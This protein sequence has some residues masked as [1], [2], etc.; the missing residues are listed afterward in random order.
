MTT[1]QEWVK[2]DT[3]NWINDTNYV[4]RYRHGPTTFVEYRRKEFATYTFRYRFNSSML[5]RL[6]PICRKG[7]PPMRW[8]STRT[9]SEWLQFEPSLALVLRVKLVHERRR[10]PHIYR[11]HLKID[12]CEAAV[13][14]EPRQEQTRNILTT[15]Q[16]FTSTTSPSDE[17]VIPSIL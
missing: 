11:Y 7:L 13:P 16:S 4:E 9:S 8:K 15:K 6:S 14:Q 1:P 2:R 17:F 5:I 12:L 3:I 10:R